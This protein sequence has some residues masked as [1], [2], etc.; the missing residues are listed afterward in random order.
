MFNPAV[1]SPCQ[2]SDASCDN[3]MEYE[4]QGAREHQ[5]QEENTAD[6]GGGI[7]QCFQPGATIEIRDTEIADQQF[8]VVN[9]DAGNM[10]M[11]WPCTG[12]GTEV[13]CVDG[14]YIR[15]PRVPL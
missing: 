8:V 4:H 1:Y 7:L 3:L 11:V 6:I 10:R 13:R 5:K 12:L 14:A 15:D 9:R 2:L